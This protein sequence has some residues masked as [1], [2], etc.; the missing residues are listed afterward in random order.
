MKSQQSFFAL[1]DLV[2]SVLLNKEEKDSCRDCMESFGQ[3]WFVQV[4][5]L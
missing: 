2:P 4:Y 1:S 3:H 5:I